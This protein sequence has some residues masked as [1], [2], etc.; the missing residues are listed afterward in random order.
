MP[1][2]LLPNLWLSDRK[3]GSVSSTPTT[4]ESDAA[5]AALTVHSKGYKPVAPIVGKRGEYQVDLMFVDKYG[6]IFF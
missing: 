2:K 3:K 1:P 6:L 5:Q 4:T